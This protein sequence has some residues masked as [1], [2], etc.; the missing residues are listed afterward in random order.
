M[1]QD[2]YQVH[3][4]ELHQFASYLSQT[5]YEQVSAAKD[6]VRAANNFDYDAFGLF[7]G[8]ALSFP[9]RMAIVKATDNLEALKKVI[10]NMGEE[11]K[12]T[13]DSYAQNE[14]DLASN[15]DTIHKEP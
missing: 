5:A 8:Q 12:N 13:A 6:S 15:F 2:G 7:L 9:A 11:T 1:A 14:Q 3:P 4:E 10:S